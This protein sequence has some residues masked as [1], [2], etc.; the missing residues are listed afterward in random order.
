[1]LSKLFWF[2]LGAG[3]MRYMM[4]RPSSGLA[5]GGSGLSRW[6]GAAAGAAG[7]SAGGSQ[8]LQQSALADD[9]T[10]TLMSDSM[11]PDQGQDDALQPASTG[12]GV[13]GARSK[14]GEQG[15]EKA[16]T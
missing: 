9:D 3:A 1:M 12:T 13:Q 4:N 8:G 6:S 10:D 5:A 11:L 2:A 16:Y 15:A 7:G 14:S